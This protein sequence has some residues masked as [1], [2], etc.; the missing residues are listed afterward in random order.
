MF[1]FSLKLGLKGL[2]LPTLLFF[3]SSYAQVSSSFVGCRAPSS[4]LISA[5][6]L[7]SFVYYTPRPYKEESYIVRW[8]FV[9][10][11]KD[12]IAFK[13]P[14]IEG[15]FSYRLTDFSTDG[16]RFIF[17]FVDYVYVYSIKNNHL[18]LQASK[19]FKKTIIEQCFFSTNGL[20]LV[21][22]SINNKG[23]EKKISYTTFLLEELRNIS[24]MGSELSLTH[25]KPANYFAFCN[26]YLMWLKPVSQTIN[27]YLNGELNNSKSLKRHF[28]PP[29]SNLKQK[30]NKQWGLE[31]RMSIIMSEFDSLE[32]DYLEEIYIIDETTFILFSAKG[33]GMG[34]KK[35]W[36]RFIA[37]LTEDYSKS[38]RY[39][40]SNDVDIMK[41]NAF[42]F[43][44]NLYFVENVR[45][46]LKVHSMYDI[47][48]TN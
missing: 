13:H 1:S 48:K 6:G 35:P 20:V 36:N 3:S 41:L 9:S 37:V 2:V 38:E 43:N 16:V 40:I 26:D 32:F 27:F 47:S 4:N 46:V 23:D 22:S 25:L 34:V 8:N 39:V 11:V 17:C 44:K 21:T 5:I 18:K 14:N 7:D 28:A 10:N 33:S 15:D 29:S 24:L 30:L 45:G 19:H 12:S 31:G 42:T